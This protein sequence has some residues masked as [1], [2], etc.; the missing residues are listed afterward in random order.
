MK[1]GQTV[2]CSR[3]P[4]Q[5]NLPHPELACRRRLSRYARPSG[6]FTVMDVPTYR[7]ELDVYSGP[8]ELLLFLI[9]KNEVDIYD[10]PIARITSQYLAHVEV[11]RQI[12]INL[13]GDFL[14]M[15]ATLM[16]IK[17]RMLNPQPVADTAG[18]GVAET[19]IDPRQALVEQLLQY[20]RYKDAANHLQRRA[21]TEQLR[22]TRAVQKS[23]GRAPLDIEDLNLFQLIDA[24]TAI[25]ASVGH[26][27]YGHDVV[28][29]DTPISLHQADILDRVH[30]DGSIT[31]Q[32]LFIGRKSKSEMIGLF[33]AMLELIRLK[34]LTFEQTEAA[35]R[36]LL[37]PGEAAKAESAGGA[38][39]ATA[40]RHEATAVDDPAP[41]AISHRDVAAPTPE[42]TDAHAEFR[43]TA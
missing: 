40:G 33:L 42:A 16:E 22:F 30:R 37:R 36:I 17:S 34:K 3:R 11:I 19:V 38:D 35:G 14:V 32:E 12:D 1:A 5:E 2:S 27:A 24:F 28:Y 31:L 29:D 26:S 43:P 6:I 25:M 21:H 9:R 13:A 18:S 41:D 39:T 7:V 20:K 23:T 10:I 4:H 8:L 15:A